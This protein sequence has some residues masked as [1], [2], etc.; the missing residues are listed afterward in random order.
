M[1]LSNGT[2]ALLAQP[3]DGGG[4]PSHSTI[5]LI[6]T[7]ADAAEY[8]PDEGNKMDRVLS[9][10]RSLQ[11]G[12]RDG[13]GALVLAADEAK[14][15]LV[16]ADLSTRLMATG[17]V[18]DETL[19][20]AFARDG[21][22]VNDGDVV[23]L[24]PPDEPADRLALRLMEIFADRPELDVARNHFGQGSRAFDRGDY[25]AANAQF[26]SACDATFDA[27][28]RNHGCAPEMSGGRARQW[29]QAEGLLET[30]EADLTKTF[31]AF[32]GR[33]GSH[34]GLSSAADSQLRRHFAT[35]LIVF[36]IA[37]LGS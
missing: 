33:A 13:F 11:T 5:D 26:R 31:M 2:L 8:L 14:L 23:E 29:L 37:K 21:I 22:A 6:W 30:D 20:A 32:A 12:R 15:R 34:A 28:A 4:G 16:V 27:L 10:L 18:D 17:F 25:E 7:M 1:A 36:A 24:R 9:G 3:F 35:A 19:E